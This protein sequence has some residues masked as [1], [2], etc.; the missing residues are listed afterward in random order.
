[1]SNGHILAFS[2]HFIFIFYKWTRSCFVAS[3]QFT[4][5]FCFPFALVHM[6]SY[7]TFSSDFFSIIIG[8]SL[9]FSSKSSRLSMLVHFMSKLKFIFEARIRIKGSFYIELY[10]IEYRIRMLC[11]F[12]HTDYYC[13]ERFS[14]SVFSA[15]DTLKMAM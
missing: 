7:A 14:T 15:R 9:A 4:A 2:C 5:D 13:D 8:I 1:M 6:T 3:F 12:P 11:Y 10:Y